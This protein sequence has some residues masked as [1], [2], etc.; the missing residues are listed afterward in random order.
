MMEFRFRRAKWVEYAIRLAS[1]RIR[2]VST[3]RFTS[4]S[5]PTVEALLIAN[6][7][8]AMLD[9]K[10]SNTKPKNNERLASNLLCV[11]FKS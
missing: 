1:A 3:V 2:I 10:K 7:L 5:I 4:I 11:I 8:L 9:V 6:S